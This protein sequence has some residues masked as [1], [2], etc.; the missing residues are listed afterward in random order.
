M[1]KH[2]ILFIALLAFGVVSAQNGELD[3][4]VLARAQEMGKAFIAKDYAAFAK[5]A[6]PRVVKIEKG[7]EA[8][9]KKMVKDFGDLESEGVT[10][11]EVNFGEPSKMITVENELQ[12]VIQQQVV[13]LVPGGKLTATTSLI[14]LSEDQGKNWYFV[15]AAGNNVRNMKALIPSLSLDLPVTMPVDPIFEP[16]V[17]EAAAP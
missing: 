4:M 17:E 11:L 14:A 10:F 7:E 12:C 8:M 1:K 15:D 13:M 5:F 2:L 3:Q 16:D 9:I 6:H